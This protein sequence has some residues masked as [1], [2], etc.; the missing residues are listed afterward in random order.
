[1]DRI[2]K[3]PYYPFLHLYIY[4]VCICIYVGVCNCICICICICIYCISSLTLSSSWMLTASWLWPPSRP[5]SAYKQL[6]LVNYQW[7]SPILIAHPYIVVVIQDHVW[8]D[9][10]DP[11]VRGHL[12]DPLGPL[13]GELGS[14]QVLLHCHPCRGALAG[15]SGGVGLTLLGLL[16]H[17]F[18]FFCGVSEAKR[19]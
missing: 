19:N 8:G 14:T 12:V 18:E 6:L 2:I 7:G 9:F 5:G 11:L 4:C 17:S 3:L 10:I 16:L 13:L 1:M 15:A